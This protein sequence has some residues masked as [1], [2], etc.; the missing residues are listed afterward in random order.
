MKSKKLFATLAAASALVVAF[1][2][3]GEAAKKK[4]K[5][6]AVADG[7]TIKGKVSFEGALPD[8][9]IEK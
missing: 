7:G 5:E 6:V 9:A 4:Y 3:P 8:D 2:G 1:A